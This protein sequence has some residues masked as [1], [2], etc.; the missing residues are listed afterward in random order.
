MSCDCFPTLVAGGS[1]A[2]QMTSLNTSSVV[3]ACL[4]LSEAHMNQQHPQ[5]VNVVLS[6]KMLTNPTHGHP[7]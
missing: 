1:F 6:H 4:P 5:G 2:K 3:M 7:I